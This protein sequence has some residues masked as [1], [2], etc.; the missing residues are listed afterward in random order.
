M[1]GWYSDAFS[2][3]LSK[4][5]T[6]KLAGVN[7][8]KAFGDA[9]I[10]LGKVIDQKEQNDAKLK[11]YESELES[12]KLNQKT[13]Q[14]SLDTAYADT[15]QKAIDDAYLKNVGEDGKLDDKDGSVGI[16][17]NQVSIE[18][19]EKADSIAQ[20]KFNDTALKTANNYNSWNEFKEANSE[21]IENADGSTVQKIKTAFSSTESQVNKLKTQQKIN[22]LE[23]KL[24]KA[25]IK[26]MQDS[27]ENKGFKY[28]EQ[29][30]AKITNL[31][32]SAL[33]MDNELTQLTDEKKQE[34]NAMVTEVSHLSKTYGLEPNIAY[35][36]WLE[37]NKENQSENKD[38]EEDSYKNYLP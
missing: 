17:L 10:N 7:I 19:K 26:A 8:S 22:D 16:P 2:S 1:G 11:L 36:M 18:A 13:K 14:H 35:S 32:K 29:T 15:T 9:M 33:G 28:T 23:A 38:T 20:K 31:V 5:D 34:F 4:V 3:D 25:E 27:K 37:K 24:D 30:G 21:L 12:E 6:T